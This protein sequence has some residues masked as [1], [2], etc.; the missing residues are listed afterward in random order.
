MLMRTRRGLTTNGFLAAALPL[1]ALTAAACMSS[2]QGPATG[3]PPD[4]RPRS[5]AAG[6]PIVHFPHSLDAIRQITLRKGRLGWGGLEVGMT[7]HQAEQV[8]RHK[9]PSL[10]SATQD[11]LCGFYPLET[12]LMQQ[13]LNLEFSA[14]GGDSHLQA[15][16]LSLEGRT[17]PPGR[18]EIVAALR[19][20][21]PKLEYLPSP[22]E[23]E[24]VEAKNPRPLYRLADGGEMLFVLPGAVYFGEVC[25]D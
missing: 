3:P 20:R 21:F 7:F 12:E 11:D 15:I 10:G 13:P 19:A 6:G 4:S 9:L 2:G 14:E 24:V 16:F 1:L 25:V 17:G 5:G 18:D 22:H 8:L 23:P